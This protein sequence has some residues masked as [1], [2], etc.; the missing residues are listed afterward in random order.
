MSYRAPHQ[1]DLT[2]KE[3]SAQPLHARTYYTPGPCQGGFIGPSVTTHDPSSLAV[4]PGSLAVR[5]LSW[6]RARLSLC[7]SLDS[8]LEKEH[9]PGPE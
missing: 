6:A 2:E 7:W 5:G 4:M 3:V 8:T 9:L 1:T